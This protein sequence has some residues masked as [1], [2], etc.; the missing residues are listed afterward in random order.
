MRLIW[1]V[2]L[3]GGCRNPEYKLDTG[4]LYDDTGDGGDETA[5]DTEDLTRNPIRFFT[6]QKFRQS[7][8]IICL[9]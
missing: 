4:T 8:A 5:I 3:L 6:H 2:L 1:L 7:G 9:A